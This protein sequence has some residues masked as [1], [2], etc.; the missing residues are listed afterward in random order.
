M[1][2][3]GHADEVGSA[4]QIAQTTGARTFTPFELGSWLT[5]QGVRHDAASLV[6]LYLRPTEAELKF[7]GTP[8]PN[9]IWG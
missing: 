4:V 9:V 3:D 6:P 7:G 2:A 1:L 5:E 8:D